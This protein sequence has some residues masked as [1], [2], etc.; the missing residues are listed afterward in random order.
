MVICILGIAT[1]EQHDRT[2]AALDQLKYPWPQITDASDSESPMG[3]YGFDGIPMLFL[4]AP[5]GT[6]LHRGI[7]GRGISD[8]VAALAR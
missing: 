6:I 3:L 8:A 1:W 2:L 5:D 7:R 4:I